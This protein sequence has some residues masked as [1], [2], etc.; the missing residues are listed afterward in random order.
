MHKTS[1]L[2]RKWYCTNVDLNVLLCSSKKIMIHCLHAKAKDKYF[3]SSRQ[4][5]IG[6]S[7]CLSCK[8]NVPCL[9][10]ILERGKKYPLPWQFPLHTYVALHGHESDLKPP[11]SMS[12]AR[13][14]GWL[15]GFSECSSDGQHTAGHSTSL[16]G[17]QIQ[18]KTLQN[19]SR[20]LRVDFDFC[21]DAE[22]TGL[23]GQIWIV[24]LD[25]FRSKNRALVSPRRLRN[26]TCWMPLFTARSPYTDNFQSPLPIRVFLNR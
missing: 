12:P 11:F 3:L 6:F 5:K 26:L 22:R 23:F 21:F 17:T 7:F 15:M 13:A 20:L 9:T 2:G 18:P 25:C 24:Q 10:T 1:N 4:W 19:R 14:K 8:W 16:W